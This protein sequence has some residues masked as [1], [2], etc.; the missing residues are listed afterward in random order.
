MQIVK[1]LRQSIIFKSEFYQS[2]WSPVSERGKRP[3]ARPVTQSDKGEEFFGFQSFSGYLYW[4]LE[5][6]RVQ[7]LVCGW[8]WLEK[9]QGWVMTM[10]WIYWC[11]LKQYCDIDYDDYGDNLSKY[12]Y[13]KHKHQVDP[14]H[15]KRKSRSQPDILPRIILIIW[16]C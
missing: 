6:L 9:D 13:G 4:L 1:F 8:L 15:L 14:Q 11:W 7:T 2:W 3:A 10:S 5:E 12:C 16:M